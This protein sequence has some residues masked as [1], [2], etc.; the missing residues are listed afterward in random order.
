MPQTG[1]FTTVVLLIGISLVGEYGPV[2]P[3]RLTGG[4]QRRISIA[5]KTLFRSHDPN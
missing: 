2:A 3:Q 1:S 4:F 5:L